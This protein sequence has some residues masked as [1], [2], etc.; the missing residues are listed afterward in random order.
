MPRRIASFA[1]RGIRREMLWASLALFLTSSAPLVA[2]DASGT[3]FWIAF[4]TNGN[5]GTIS[6]L[7]LGQSG[8]IG[9]VAVPGLAYSAPFSI[10]AQ[11]LATVILP[12]GAM[13]TASDG[14]ESLGVHVTASRPV[15]VYGLD[16]EAGS[17][18]SFLALPVPEL[19]TTYGTVSYTPDP[20]APVFVS[21]FA[22][23]ATA[24]STLVTVTPTAVVGAHSAGVP[25]QVSLEAGQVYQGQSSGDLTGTQIAANH[26]IA[27][28]SGDN[29]TNV[30]TA[31]GYA[32]HLAEQILPAAAWSTDVVAVPSALRTAPER[33]RVQAVQDNTTVTL[34]TGG[35]FTLN[36]GQYVESTFGSPV[37]FQADHPISV[38]HFA[39]GATADAGPGDPYLIVELAAGRFAHGF[40][41][42]TADDGTLFPSNYVNIVAPAA[43]VGRIALDGARIGGG[44]FTAISGTSYYYSRQAIAAGPHRLLGP[45]PFG[46]SVYGFG[47]FVSYGSPAGGASLPFL[48]GFESGDT[49]SWSSSAP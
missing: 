3:E 10:T 35:G 34:S 39:N 48:D 8:T 38:A 7:I 30:P 40:L 31:M 41:L 25:Y 9:T 28:L 15:I 21:Q 29:Y 5:V 14:V 4:E 13:L 16:L 18:D 1:R 37:L 24:A 32:D 36:A 19:G 2:A 44:D 45:L 6:V 12:A 42:A 47:D 11:G 46:A 26:A 27:V 49:L 43:A 22:V 17:S 23:V 33:Y 20:G